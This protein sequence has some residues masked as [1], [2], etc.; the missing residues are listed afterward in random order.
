MHIMNGV[1][2]VRRVGR[3]RSPDNFSIARRTLE[4]WM[5]ASTVL[6]MQ[7]PSVG[8]GGAHRHTDSIA[9]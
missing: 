5:C 6:A 4:V 3:V 7:Y 1:W 8:A 9:L 2:V